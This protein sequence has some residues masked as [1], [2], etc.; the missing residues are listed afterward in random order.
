MLTRTLT[1]G[2]SSL[3]LAGCGITGNF[4]HDPGYADF[5]AL[6]HLSADSHIG[7][8]LGP[9]PLKIAAWGINLAEDDEDAEEVGSFLRELR[10]VRVYTFDGVEEDPAEVESGVKELTAELA[11]DGWLNIAVVREESELTS[12]FLRPDK[13]FT[14]H[15]L[16]V[17]VQ[18]PDE[19]VLVNLI[20][21]I[22]LDFI[23][24]YLADLDVHVPPI[25]IDPAALETLQASL[26]S[27]P[28]GPAAGI[29]P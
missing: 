29:D 15:G 17:V 19:V 9:V 1:L 14:H 3:L 2:A 5:G 6:Q 24:G 10:A 7:L 20:G 4:R 18:E 13:N 12:V 28:A 21:N 16:V 26:A 8:S 27:R 11:R 22:R 23:D 25:E